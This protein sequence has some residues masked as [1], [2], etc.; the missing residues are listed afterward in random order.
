VPHRALRRQQVT[1]RPPT[2]QTPDYAICWTTSLQ[3]LVIFPSRSPNGC[4]SIPPN[5]CPWLNAPP[6]ILGS[7]KFKQ[8]FLWDH[9]L[10]YN[11][12]IHNY[13]ILGNIFNPHRYGILSTLQGMA[14]G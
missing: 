9:M 12:L 10:F 7:R 8:Y 13:C 11:L 6:F 4:G 5:K 3:F 2:H 1:E 14:G